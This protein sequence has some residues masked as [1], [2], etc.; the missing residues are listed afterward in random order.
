MR[1]PV[2]NDSATDEESTVN[3]RFMRR[4][5]VQQLFLSEPNPFRAAVRLEH[6]CWETRADLLL[7]ADIWT[8]WPS[9]FHTHSSE[10]LSQN[11]KKWRKKLCRHGQESL[12]ALLSLLINRM[13]HTSDESCMVTC[14]A[15]WRTCSRRLKMTN[16]WTRLFFFSSPTRAR[17]AEDRFALKPEDFTQQAPFRQSSF[18]YAFRINHHFTL[19]PTPQQLYVFVYLSQ[20][21]QTKKTDLA[22]E[23]C[24]EDRII[25]GGFTQD[26]SA[27]ISTITGSVSNADELHEIT[28]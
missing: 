12:P 13:W 21:T 5:S 27:R 26:A 16:D 14:W 6:G 20:E 10:S 25:K 8:L 19:C 22:R 18:E 15:V 4:I 11:W 23:R 24:T 2:H 1:E 28:R 7:R 3:T 9:T 17:A